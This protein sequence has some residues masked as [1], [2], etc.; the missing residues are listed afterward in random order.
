MEQRHLI[1]SMDTVH[2]STCPWA[3]VM[4]RLVNMQNWCY[5]VVWMPMCMQVKL[6]EDVR[7]AEGDLTDQLPELEPNF[8]LAAMATSMGCH[9][10]LIRASGALVIHPGWN[11]L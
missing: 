6:Q 11:R 7:T 9:M 3:A 4:F 5:A 2:R 8:S 1:V 10:S